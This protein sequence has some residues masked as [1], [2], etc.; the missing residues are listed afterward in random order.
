M[1]AAIYA[2]YILAF[3]GLVIRDLPFNG[4]PDNAVST[5]FALRL[6]APATVNAPARFRFERC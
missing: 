4:G 3:N 1:L 5:G 2:D 6:A